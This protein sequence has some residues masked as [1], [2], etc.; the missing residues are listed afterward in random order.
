MWTMRAS[1]IAVALVASYAL[2]F[3]DLSPATGVNARDAVAVAVGASATI[4]GFL[5]S[6]GAL[7]YAVANTRLVRNLH[8]TGHIGSLLG[9]LFLDAGLFLLTV[10]VGMACLLLSDVPRQPD[11][12]SLFVAGLRV[13]GF[14]FVLSCAFILPV[15]YK[16]WVLLTNLTPDN[17]ERLE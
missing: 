10:L 15:G 2:T 1:G 7:V 14:W 16:M 4:L 17:A 3:I 12:V 5:V 13:F 6:A 8:R 9:D 11:E